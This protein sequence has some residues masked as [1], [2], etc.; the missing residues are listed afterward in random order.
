MPESALIN[1]SS[2]IN[3]REDPACQPPLS[4]M[5][6]A[7]LPYYSTKNLS[8]DFPLSHIDPRLIYHAFMHFA[9]L[10]LLQSNQS[11]VFNL[12]I[13]GNYVKG[14]FSPSYL[15][16]ATVVIESAPNGLDQHKIEL[17]KTESSSLDPLFNAREI[18]ILRPLLATPT[19]DKEGKL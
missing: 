12:F 1:T 18:F 19:D 3:L 10:V 7:V 9:E 17:S 11:R 14:P 13:D 15:S 8:F 5:N 16:V 4:V 6:T 2:P